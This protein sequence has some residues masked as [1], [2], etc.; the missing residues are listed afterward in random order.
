MI[1]NK[2]LKTIPFDKLY[3]IYT[4]AA[5]AAVEGIEQQIQA[6]FEH[7]VQQLEQEYADANEAASEVSLAD[8][9]VRKNYD[10]NE[11]RRKAGNKAITEIWIPRYKLGSL[12]ISVMPQIM[13]HLTQKHVILDEVSTAEGLIDGKKVLKH[14]FDFSNDWERGLYL[15]LL[16][17]SRSAYL[18]TQYKGEGRQFCALVPLIP[19]AFKVHHKVAYSRWDRATLHW[20]VNPSLCTAMLYTPEREFTREEL[21]H[22]RELGLVYQSGAKVGESRNP[23]SSFKLWATKGACLSGTPDLVQ[24]MYAQ[25]WCAHPQNRSHYMVLDPK[26]WDVMPTPL[27]TDAIFMPEPKSFGPLKDSSD[28]LPWL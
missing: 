18:P 15:F 4:E 24:V 17:D 14:I 13:A 11:V 25:I 6:Q 7:Q 21:L 8:Q 10:K 27:I 28:D 5:D 23:Q 2:Q 22:A 19:Y 3:H 16:L 12:L 26:N 9:V 20:V 1:I